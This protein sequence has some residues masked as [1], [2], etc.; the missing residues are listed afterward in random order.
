MYSIFDGAFT[1]SQ[2]ENMTLGRIDELL[3]AK[4]ASDIKNKQTKESKR[5]EKD[6]R[7]MKFM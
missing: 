1:F 3:A 7:K 2:I 4:S 6:M 5:L